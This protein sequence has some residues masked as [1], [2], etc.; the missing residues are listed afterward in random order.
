MTG[1]EFISSGNDEKVG[2]YMNALIAHG[3]LCK[4][5]CAGC[6]KAKWNCGEAVKKMLNSEVEECY[7]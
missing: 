6:K 4:Q 2:N 7:K 1:R 5:F 3:M